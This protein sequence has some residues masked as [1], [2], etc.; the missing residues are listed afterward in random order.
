MSRL[1]PRPPDPP[2]GEFWLARIDLFHGLERERVQ[3]IAAS[4]RIVR[5][6][7]GSHFFRLGQPA[8]DLY[9]LLEG[10]AKL[11]LESAEGYQVLFGFLRPGQT[12][13]WSGFE[14]SETHRSSALAVRE[15]K[16][17][18]WP[19][20]TMNGFL[21]RIPHL[22]FTALRLQ[23]HLLFEAQSRFLELAT[24]PVERRLA[25]S[26]LRLARQAPEETGPGVR[27]DPPVTRQD[28]ADMTAT[29]VF[30]VSRI[31]SR[32]QRKGIVETGRMRIE[33]RDALGLER[34]AGER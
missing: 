5:L 11:T 16:A 30:T 31:L 7:A 3:E 21:E 24:E 14:S 29:S 18:A 15:C 28:L 10:R 33:V 4:S 25:R 1:H 26:L 27:I 23:V 32:W 17:L 13:G 6:E 34:L 12:F 19:Q 9:A 22:A 8:L 20:K 2:S